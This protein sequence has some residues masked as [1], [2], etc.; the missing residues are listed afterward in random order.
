MN[1]VIL[2]GHVFSRSVFVS[3]SREVCVDFQ[4]RK[5]FLSVRILNRRCF[6]IIFY[7]SVVRRGIALVKF[8]R[9]LSKV[10][11][12]IFCVCGTRMKESSLRGAMTKKGLVSF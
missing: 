7:S 1:D 6:P 5:F 9:R 12:N 3:H 10:Q 4:R 11:W 8:L 2:L